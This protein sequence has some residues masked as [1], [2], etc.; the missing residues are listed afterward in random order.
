MKILILTPNLKR[1]GAERVLSNLSLE[2]SKHHKIIFSLFDNKDI[3]YPY[4]GKITNIGFVKNASK[5][6]VTLN[7]KTLNLDAYKH[8]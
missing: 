3:A 4:G 8:F 5:G 6:H 1:G 2:W 7:N